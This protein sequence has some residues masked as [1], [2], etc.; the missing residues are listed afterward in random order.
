MTLVHHCIFNVKMCK[1]KICTTVYC[2][3]L[4]GFAPNSFDHMLVILPLNNV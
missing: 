3:S 2:S 4:Y 1:L